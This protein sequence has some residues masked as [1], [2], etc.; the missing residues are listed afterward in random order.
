M[1]GWTAPPKA[2]P[3][4][5]FVSRQTTTRVMAAKRVEAEK[6]ET[7]MSAAADHDINN[8]W[9][10]DHYLRRRAELGDDC[11]EVIWSMAVMARLRPELEF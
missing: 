8:L 3:R 10:A 4:K 9:A 7:Y 5:R 11:F 6:I 1:I 2:K